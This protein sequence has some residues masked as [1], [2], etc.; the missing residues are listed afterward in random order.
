MHIGPLSLSPSLTH[1]H[2]HTYTPQDLDI[3]QVLVDLPEL[4]R[5]LLVEA[6]IRLRRKRGEQGL[7]RLS[8]ARN[9]HA[10][11]RGARGGDAIECMLATRARACA[12]EGWAWGGK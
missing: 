8:S 9:E 3:G 2:T 12:G 6:R 7:Q 10:I 5:Q 4:E 1:T 11:D